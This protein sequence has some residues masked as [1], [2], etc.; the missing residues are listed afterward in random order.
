MNPYEKTAEEMK[1][2]SERPKKVAKHAIGIGSTIAAASS[3][4]PILARAAP[5]LSQY[6]PENLAIKGLSKINPK[7]GKFVKNAMDEG[8]DFKEVKDFIGGKIKESQEEEK[9]IIQKYS[10][11]LFQFIDQQVKQGV[12]PL[13]AGHKA[14]NEKKFSDVIKKMTGD[15]RTN[16]LN[17]LEMI[18]GSEMNRQKSLKGFNQ[19]KKGFIEEERERFNEGYGDQLA[20]QNQ[21]QGQQGQGIDPQ[22]SQILQQ[23]N[24][25][26]QRFKGGNG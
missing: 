9:N 2:Q 26:L 19:K 11:E 24:A 5:F 14:Q 7:F 20:Q 4:A 1:R 12:S 18:Y 17:I 8:F 10:P 23:G 22:L 15:N 16:F 21:Q 25:I 13:E 3:F 6:I